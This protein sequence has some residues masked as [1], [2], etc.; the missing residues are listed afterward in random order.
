MCT[1]DA[2]SGRGGKGSDSFVGG[3]NRSNAWNRIFAGKALFSRTIIFLFFREGRGFNLFIHSE[4]FRGKKERLSRGLFLI[5]K[6]NFKCQGVLLR[7]RVEK[8]ACC[9]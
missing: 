7:A 3:K 5:F 1:W 8:I 6:K 4:N 9:G 2:L